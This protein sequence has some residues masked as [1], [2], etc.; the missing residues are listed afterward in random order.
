MKSLFSRRHFLKAGTAV[1]LASALGSSL[2]HAADEKVV[3]IGFQKSSALITLL[4][5]QGTLEKKLAP[6][7][8][9]VSWHEFTSGLPLLESLN[10]GNIDFS[11][12]VAD[13][14]PVF[15]LAAGADLVFVAKETPS[16]TAQALLVPQDSPIKTVAD[17][18]GKRVGVAKAAGSHYLLLAALAKSGLGAKDITPAYLSP[19]DGRAAFTKGSIDAWVVWDPF[20]AAVQSQ[21]QVRVITDGSNGLAS[22]QRYYL[23]SAPFVKANPKVIKLV[24][25]ELQEAGKWVKKNPAEAAAILAPAWGLDTA[26]VEKANARRSY[27]VRPVDKAALQEAQQ[28]ADVFFKE[29]LLPKQVNVLGATVWKP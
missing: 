16:P 22:Y 15:A 14:V 27:D 9:T 4:K 13:T 21:S 24:Y 29:E 26:T 5:S 23:A 25:G 10:V 17:L 19:A 12:D 11:A 6:L 28:I 18:K 2:V 7:G 1:L 3:R 20:V 8:Y